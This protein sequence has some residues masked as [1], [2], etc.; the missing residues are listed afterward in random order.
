VLDQRSR[1]IIV[2]AVAEV[3][4][5]GEDAR[6]NY[7]LWLERLFE[8]LKFPPENGEMDWHC[9][10]NALLELSP[11]TQA[12]LLTIRTEQPAAKWPARIVGRSLQTC[13]AGSFVTTR[14]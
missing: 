9:T 12:L 3:I 2:V 11:D 8:D 6:P 1:Q 13:P 5:R 14:C 10:R 7:V 4:R